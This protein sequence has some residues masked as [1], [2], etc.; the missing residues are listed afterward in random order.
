MPYMDV[1]LHTSTQVKYSTIQV[2]W[3]DI[4]VSLQMGAKHPST[5]QKPVYLVGFVGVSPSEIF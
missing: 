2:R 3:G 4:V 5:G 1:L